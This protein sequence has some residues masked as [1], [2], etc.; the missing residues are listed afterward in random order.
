[1]AATVAGEEGME[2]QEPHNKKET[3]RAMRKILW[4]SLSSSLMIGF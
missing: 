3:K 4:T 2:Q 1:M